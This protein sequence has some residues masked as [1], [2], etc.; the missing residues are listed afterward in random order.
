MNRKLFLDKLHEARRE[1]EEALAHIPEARMTELALAG[2]WSIKDAIAHVTWS[3][4]EMIG[5]IR[6]RALVGSPHWALRTDERNA[7]VYAENR[8]R[9]LAEVLAE[10]NAVWAELLPGLEALTGEDLADPSRFRELAETAP[11]VRPWQIFAG[12]TFTH[13]EEHAADVRKWL[14]DGAKPGA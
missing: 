14:Q 4:R 13:Y 8:E 5:V 11:G 12:S 9:P 3:E 2:G 1:W 10:A 6:G 7:A